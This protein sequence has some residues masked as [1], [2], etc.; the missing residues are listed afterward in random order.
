[1]KL[2]KTAALAVLATRFLTQQDGRT[3]RARNV[4]E[5]LNIPTDS[6]LKILQALAR[7]RVID[8]HLGRSGG[9]SVQRLPRQITLLEIIEA[10]DG[11][12]TGSVAL[13]GKQPD[14]LEGPIE[15]LHRACRRVADQMRE[16][17]A[18]CTLE[19]LGRESASPPRR[20]PLAHHERAL[21]V[22]V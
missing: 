6:A 4:G 15:Q 1:M 11:P 19:E 7:S 21:H 14:E 13:D 16:Q 8:S 22:A 5:A 10:I 18:R 3:V 12:M 17:A 20:H 2:S 9:Y